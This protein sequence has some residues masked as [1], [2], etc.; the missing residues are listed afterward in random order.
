[1][2]PAGP[3][4]SQFKGTAMNAMP[5]AML[6]GPRGLN[7]AKPD[8]P[9][10]FR[11][12]LQ[13]DQA[14]VACVALERP[15]GLDTVEL[16]RLF[17]AVGDATAHRSGTIVQF[18]SNNAGGSSSD[19][20]FSAAWIGAA[21]LGKRILFIDASAGG[22]RSSAFVASI[23]TPKRLYDVALGQADVEEA[24]MRQSDLSLFIVTL[25]NERLGGDAI[26]AA[27]QVHRLLNELRNAFDMII[28][29]S[30]P[31]LEQPLAAI[32]A[33]F[34][35]GSVLVLEAEHSSSHVA[36]QS[37]ELLTSGGSRILG[38]VLNYRRNYVP[39]WLRRWL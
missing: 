34:I 18:V 5:D 14:R 20:A 11:S 6:L 25:G 27:Q 38:A 10:S 12:T 33:T 39:R 2:L 3:M 16:V 36:A 7:E 9:T 24:I 21:L 17:N 31:A 8:I 30:P 13:V 4:Q 26:L 19:V 32:L 15:V 29:A 35:D 28:I 1:M 22:D 23:S 37:V